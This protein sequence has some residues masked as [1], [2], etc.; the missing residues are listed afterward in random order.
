M[1]W[2]FSSFLLQKAIQIFLRRIFQEDNKL[3]KGRFT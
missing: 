3:G 2:V 1:S